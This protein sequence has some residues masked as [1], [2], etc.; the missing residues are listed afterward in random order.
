MI[1]WEMIR[2]HRYATEDPPDNWPKGVK[3]IS[4]EGLTLFGVDPTS[5]KLYWDGQEVA[6]RI[7][8]GWIER[9]IA[10][11]GVAS[12]FGTF[13]LKLGATVHWWTNAG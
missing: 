12:A 8:F 11:V 3:P 7:K 6:T 4:M 5:G 13:V 1:N 2:V 9:S 10:I